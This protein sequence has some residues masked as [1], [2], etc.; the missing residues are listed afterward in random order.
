LASADAPERTR[1]KR[2]WVKEGAAYLA[3]GALMPFGRKQAAPDLEVGDR[4]RVFV[5]G[6]GANR[7]IF[8]PMMASLRSHSNVVQTAVNV[9]G[10]CVEEMAEH[11]DR[12]LVH[13]APEMEVE[14]VG[15]S[16]GGLVS[17]WFTQAIDE[18]RRVR[19]LVTLGSPHY[20]TRV[21]RYVRRTELTKQ[22]REGSELTERMKGLA[23]PEGVVALSVAGKN[24]QLVRP[25]HS[26]LM[27]FGEH[28][29]I[30]DMT[31][32][33]LLYSRDVMPVLQAFFSDK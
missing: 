30:D 11:L 7:A 29:V 17:R 24:D 16:L 27:P 8:V 26:A 15:H 1:R 2:V 28:L 21:A 5:H 32:N 25:W 3:Q 31:H 10:R 14:L 22:L 12:W 6:F 33:S 19:R 23:A 13:H 9:R 18:G 4:L 20:G